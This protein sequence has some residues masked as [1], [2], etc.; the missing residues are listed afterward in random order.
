MVRPLSDTFLSLISDPGVNRYDTRIAD[1]TPIKKEDFAEEKTEIAR[2]GV[3][4]GQDS[5][6]REDDPTVLDRRKYQSLIS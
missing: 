2:S 1:F 4:A 5:F 6:V 3:A